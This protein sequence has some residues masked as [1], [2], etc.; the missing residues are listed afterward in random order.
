MVKDQAT[1]NCPELMDAARARYRDFLTKLGLMEH[2]T[3]PVTADVITGL[4]L[5]VPRRPL[6]GSPVGACAHEREQEPPSTSV[7]HSE[8]GWESGC[9]AQ[10]GTTIAGERPRGCGAGSEDDQGQRF[11]PASGSGALGVSCSRLPCGRK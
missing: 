6:P 8:G 3:H 2:V 10:Y 5:Q 9:R 1:W 4:A 7:W 11:R